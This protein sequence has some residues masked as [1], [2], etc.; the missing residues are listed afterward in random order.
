MRDGRYCVSCS[1]GPVVLHLPALPRPLGNIVWEGEGGMPGRVVTTSVIHM[2]AEAGDF[3]AL[4]VGPE[5]YT[6]SAS[7]RLPPGEMGVGLTSLD[8]MALWEIWDN[9]EVLLL[10]YHLP[11]IL[12][13]VILWKQCCI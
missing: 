1:N 4:L 2:G 8:L 11:G 13:P 12:P 6:R 9:L 7:L 3:Q 5:N 10:S